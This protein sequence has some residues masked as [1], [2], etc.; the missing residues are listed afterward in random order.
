MDE[1]TDTQR[2]KLR[3]IAGVHTGMQKVTSS[4]E[5]EPLGLAVKSQIR[6][7]LKAPSHRTAR[8]P[9][10]GELVRAQ[11]EEKQKDR[12]SWLGVQ[13]RGAPGQ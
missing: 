11:Q 10:V 7:D 1:E 5:L 3:Q 6:C 9:K 12:G 8:L 13:G 2:V 4:Q